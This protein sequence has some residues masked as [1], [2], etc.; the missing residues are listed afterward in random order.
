MNLS[1][2]DREDLE[3][4]IC[5]MMEDMKKHNLQI[6]DKYNDILED[7]M[8]EIGEEEAIEIVHSFKPYEE[9]FSMDKVKEILHRQGKSDVNCIDYYL[10][11]NMI[12]ND[13]KTF[14]EMKRMD[15]QDFCLEMSKLFIEDTDAPKHKV[16]RYFSMYIDE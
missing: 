12:Y 11:M 16:S 4:I 7:I 5:D 3:D 15:V 6:Y 14:A 13:Y 9:A 2:V 10:V 8:Y 1:R